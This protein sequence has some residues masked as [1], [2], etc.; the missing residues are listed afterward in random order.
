[1]SAGTCTLTLNESLHECTFCYLKL[2]TCFGK[3]SQV[4]NPGI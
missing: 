3:I 2:W 1:M 4:R